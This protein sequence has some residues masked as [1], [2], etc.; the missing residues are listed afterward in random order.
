MGKNN[1]FTSLSI[2]KC[3]PGALRAIYRQA[4]AYLAEAD[5]HPHFFAE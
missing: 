3:A 1:P 5:L 4:S 2:L